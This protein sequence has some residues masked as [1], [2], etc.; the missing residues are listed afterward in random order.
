VGQPCVCVGLLCL[1]CGER[2]QPHDAYGTVP[3]FQLNW[4]PISI[5]RLA[6]HGIFSRSNYSYTSSY[7]V[8]ARRF[9]R[10][11]VQLR[12]RLLLLLVLLHNLRRRRL[13]RLLGLAYR[14][15]RLRYNRLGFRH[16]ALARQW[17]ALDA[18][19]P[20]VLALPYCLVVKAH[21]HARQIVRREPRK[22]VVDQLLGCILRVLYLSHQV[23]GFLV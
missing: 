2:A 13:Q 15:P 9:G 11:E 18:N 7:L 1:L 6:I 4:N 14:L 19:R 17:I 10:L 20:L 12:A 23:D 5:L 3:S 21:H 8:L 22:R 16:P